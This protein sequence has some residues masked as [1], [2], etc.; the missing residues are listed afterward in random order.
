MGMKAV[1]GGV[2]A[3]EL[4]GLGVGPQQVSMG[5]TPG[6][7][8]QGPHECLGGGAGW[9]QA[10]P[11]FRGAA[12]PARGVLAAVHRHPQFSKWGGRRGS[13]TTPLLRHPL[14]RRLTE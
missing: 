9:G 12:D 8:C 3:E 4:R 13:V 10:R 5:G 1:G 14:S 6:G 11:A 7:R 2:G